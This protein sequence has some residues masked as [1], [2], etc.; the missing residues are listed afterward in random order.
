MGVIA[1]ILNFFLPGLGTLVFTTKRIQGFIQL[2][3][4]IINLALVGIT[5]GIWLIVGIFIHLGIFVWSIVT[6]AIFMG[7]QAAKQAAQQERERQ[8]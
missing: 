5:F 6:T 4:C 3:L 2:F 8:N 7:E 1:L